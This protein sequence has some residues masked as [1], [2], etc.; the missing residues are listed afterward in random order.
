MSRP[1]LAPLFGTL[2]LALIASACSEAGEGGQARI[3]SLQ[4]PIQDGRLAEGQPSVVGLQGIVERDGTSLRTLL[5]T[6]SLIA[7]NLVLT[8]RH[9][10]A[11]V[12]SS[13]V[14][15]GKA[16]FNDPLATRDIFVTTDDEMPSQ[17]GGY[18][19]TREVIVPDTGND[20]CG[21]DIAL[22]ILRDR[23]PSSVATPLEPRIDEP[24][25]V[26]ETYRAVGYGATTGASVDDTGAGVRRERAGLKASCIEGDSD[27][28]LSLGSEWEGQAGV[29]EGDSGGPALDGQNRV[30]GVASRSVFDGADGEL[31]LTPVYSAVAGWADFIR[32]G[33]LRAAELGNY[34]PAKWVTARPINSGGGGSGGSG[35]NGQPTGDDGNA[36]AG[37]DNGG[38]DDGCAVRAPSGRGGGALAL[39][40]AALALAAGARRRRRAG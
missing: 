15:C 31:C 18:L 40:G 36:S 16:P 32:G 13:Q 24:V 37:D 8:A 33:A 22:V 34:Q 3:S 27:C 6:G 5:C 2:S 11:R 12:A 29:C 19:P 23:V 4:A 1:Y 25:E 26:G 21:Y 39:A 20:V 14:S 7:P 9:C 17:L 10:I 35:G 30:L 28:S 38:G